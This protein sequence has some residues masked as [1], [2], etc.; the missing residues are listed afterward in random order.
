MV[1]ATGGCVAAERGTDE[2]GITGGIIADPGL[3]A[4]AVAKDSEAGW[5]C[6]AAPAQAVEWAPE[7]C[8]QAADPEW[9]PDSALAECVQE[10]EWAAV[11]KWALPAL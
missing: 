9:A 1:P 7:E 4:N 11:V 5:R 10:W 6:A 8:A 2:G 3:V